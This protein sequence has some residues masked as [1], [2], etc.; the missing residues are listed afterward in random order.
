MKRNFLLITAALPCVLIL[1]STCTKDIGRPIPEP[2][3]VV[4]DSCKTDIKFAKQIQP[5]LNT[6]CAI[7]SNCHV[8]APWGDFTTFGGFQSRAS[9]GLTRIKNGSMP[10][11]NTLGPKNLTPC[12]ISK[13]EAWIAAG[14]PNN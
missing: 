13:L 11:S 12:E 3:V 4:V 6:Y 2:V 14:T 8:A 9:Y 10:P 5:I 7:N 1:F